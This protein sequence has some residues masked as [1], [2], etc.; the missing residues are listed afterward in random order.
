MATEIGS[1]TATD[2]GVPQPAGW[3]LP[4]VLLAAVESQAAVEGVTPDVIAARVVEAGLM[5]LGIMLHGRCSVRTGLCG[6]GPI[7]LP[8][9][10]NL[11]VVS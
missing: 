7:P 6:G 2:K 4:A 10:Q 1:E 8:I 3:R 9:Q 5:E 11:S